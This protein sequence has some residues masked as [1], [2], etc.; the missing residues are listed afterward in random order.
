MC[1]GIFTRFLSVTYF[2]GGPI[3]GTMRKYLI[4]VSI[5]GLLE[6]VVKEMLS[7]KALHFD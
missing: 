1:L 6:S 7:E 5:E 3:P 4:F 2:L